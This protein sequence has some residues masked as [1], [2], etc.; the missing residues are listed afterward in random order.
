M[1]KI[2][3][4]LIIII[5]LS[6]GGYFYY[7]NFLK[8]KEVHF[9]AGFQVY[10]NGKL[11]DFSDLK[12]MHI[13]PCT[14]KKN[15]IPEDEQE[16]KAHLHD[17]VGDVVHV[18]RDNAVWQD[19]FTNIKY[20]IDKTKPIE[21]YINGKKTEG[22]LHKPIHPYDIMLLLIGKHGNINYYLK[23]SVKKNHILKIEKKS[24]SCGGNG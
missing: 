9:H 8:P 18:H 6:I 16:E 13:D 20:K 3:V 7:L 23:N 10:V 14:T 1:K 19:L 22:I 15:T 21:G 4:V 12:Y 2:L 5:L 17:F 11:Q 24:E